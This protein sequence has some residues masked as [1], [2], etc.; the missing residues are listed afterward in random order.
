MTTTEAKTLL[1]KYA[2]A[3]SENELSL[4]QKYCDSFVS[5]IS[6][7][8][9][10]L[11]EKESRLY[12]LAKG[13]GTPSSEGEILLL[14]FKKMLEESKIRT[15]QE[16]QIERLES[17]KLHQLKAIN[18]LNETVNNLKSE[19]NSLRLKITRLDAQYR[20]GF[21]TNIN[22]NMQCP[23]CFGDGGIRQG[24]TKCDGSGFI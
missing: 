20:G 18:A 8:R 4:L 10:P 7:S 15:H 13:I 9:L 23:K 16:T 5:L 19:V 24:C 14:K 6:A 3:Y 12:Q 2:V 1:A 21:G 17:D 22:E 11:D